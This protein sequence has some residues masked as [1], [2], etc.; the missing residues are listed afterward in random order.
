M[1]LDLSKLN[2]L[3][4]DYPFQW[5]HSS[6]QYLGIWITLD[7]DM[8]YEASFGPYLAKVHTELHKWQDLTITRFGGRSSFK[9]TNLFQMLYLIQKLPIFVPQA[10]LIRGVK[11]PPPSCTHFSNL[12]LY[13]HNGTLGLPNLSQ[14]YNTLHLSRFES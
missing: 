2:I 3:K 12:T 11:S 14:Y 13:K 9:M 10:F 1:S 8:L 7:P 5:V 4:W 6:L